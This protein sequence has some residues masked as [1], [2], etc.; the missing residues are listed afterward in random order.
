[1]AGMKKPLLILAA[2]GSLSYGAYRMFGSHDSKPAAQPVAEVNEGLTLDRIWI[3]HIPRNE[4]DTI[5]VFVAISEEPF[6]IFQAASQWKGAYEMFRYEAHGNELRVIYPQNNDRETIKHSARACND[7]SFD[8]CLEL[9]GGRGV[10]KYYSRKGWEIEN[11]HSQ[12]ELDDRTDHILQS[13]K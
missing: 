12:A 4:R 13:I 8:Y 6:G 3:D 7:G 2:L 11:V 1:M 9:K 5:Q 10:K